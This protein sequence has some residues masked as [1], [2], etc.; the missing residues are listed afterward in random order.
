MHLA[1]LNV[2]PV[3]TD[4]TFRHQAYVALRHAITQ[5]NI[6]AVKGPVRLDERQLSQDL[7][8]SRT[9]IREAMTVLER[10]G[11]VQTLPRRGVFVVKKTRKEIVEMIVA[12]AALESMAAR[13][14][15]LRATDEEIASLRRLFEGFGADPSDHL[16]EYSDANLKFHQQ[17]IAAGGNG[18]IAKLTDDL[19]IH[20]RAIRQMTIR[21][22]HRAGRSIRDHMAIIEALE[23]RDTERAEALCREHTL[24]LARHV[25]EHCDY[26]D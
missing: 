5:M 16:N 15:T 10:E 12:W 1:S 25:E 24:H 4:I 9:P 7:G 11:L 3:D 14:I 13:L 20:V 6:Y 23:R 17:L 2:K 19:L 18:M 8:V 22:E 26:L 21:D